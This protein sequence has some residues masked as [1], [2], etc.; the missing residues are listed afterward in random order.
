MDLCLSGLPP[1]H[2]GNAHAVRHFMGA[3]DEF[4]ALELATS[5]GSAGRKVTASPPHA[6]NVLSPARPKALSEQAGTTAQYSLRQP[7]CGACHTLKLYPPSQRNFFW[8][9][10]S[11]ARPLPVQYAW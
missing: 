7:L 2:I 11:P 5:G 10:E 3:V 1:A 8:R 6:A 4:G 9:P